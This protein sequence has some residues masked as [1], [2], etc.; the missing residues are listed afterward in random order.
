MH[1][2]S[3]IYNYLC[4][5]YLSRHSNK[6]TSMKKTILFASVIALAIV[7]TFFGC[8]DSDKDLYDASFK[9]PNPM[10]D[11]FAAPDG[12][13]WST[14]ANIQATIEV[15]DKFDGKYYYTVELYDANPIIS[16]SAQLLDR[17]VAKKGDPYSSKISLDKSISTLFIKEI[18][19]TGLYTVRAADISNGKVNCN[20]STTSPV[21]RSLAVTRGNTTIKEP[22]NDDTS[23]FPTQSDATE[24][25]VG[26]GSS[27]PEGKYNVTSSTTNIS[28][29]GKGN[30]TL[31]VTEDITLKSQLYLTPGSRLY[32][33]P[34]IKVTMPQAKNNGQSNCLISIGKGASLIVEGDIQLDSNYRL[35]N[36]GTFNAKSL[37]CTSNSFFYNGGTVNVEEKISGENTNCT[38]L[39][40]GIAKAGSFYIQGDSHLLNQGKME[41]VEKTE[42]NCTNGSW[43]NEGEWI[44]NDM[45]M[46]AWNAQAYN[47]CKL[48]IKDEF[49]MGASTLTNDAGSYVQCK[50]LYMNNA[51]ILLGGGAL[52]KVTEEAEYGYQTS[53]KGFR[54]TG[55]EKALVVITKAVAKEDKENIIHYTG[56]LQIVC[57]DHP[58]AEISPGKIRW[59]MKD[60]AEWAEIGKNT[61]TIPKT[62]CN[63][64]FNGGTPGTPT[65]PDFPIIVED[66][67][68]YSY[69]FEDQWPLYG[70]YDMNDIVLTVNKRNITKKKQ[71]VSK[72]E[73]S[74]ELS[75]V[76]ATKLIAAALMLDDVKAS[77]ITSPIVFDNGTPIGFDLNSN[78][79]EKG[80][81]FAVIPLFADAHVAM[82]NNRRDFINTVSGATSN[83]NQGKKINF[84]INFEKPLPTESF[85]INKFNIF[86]ITDQNGIKRREIHVAGYQPTQLADT[87]IF[88]GN[89]DN[90]SLSSKRYYLSN[91]NLAWGVMVPTN[92][93]WSLEYVNI[94]LAY[95]GFA[96]WVTSGG[97]E[98]AHWWNNFNESKVYQTNKN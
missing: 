4:D 57:S 95:E 31:Y 52:F 41:V 78:N 86:I 27:N 77:D 6:H 49:N 25:F 67:K 42:V 15:N 89:N 16:K 12:F 22:D 71:E 1:L 53:D 20:F 32:I 83:T 8:V 39:N 97:Q 88:G 93:K 65:D 34:G 72:L 33:L 63:E 40:T 66:N 56:A 79:I 92:F 84:T 46:S 19:P 21:A 30:I 94:K 23:L 2:Y 36:L 14:M 51:T 82:G 35:F 80:Q 24:I 68:E 74:I 85:N 59:T 50:E 64:G 3:K 48:L 47:R 5:R 70:D 38:M 18:S 37:M 98:N 28:L 96:S 81:E 10:G 45:S 13:D 55:N 90:S 29:G 75:A 91:E 61:I 76:G 62:D 17:D 73:F 44:T 43:E 58:N 54:G 9:M 26:E 7:S 60:G 87:S 11:G 69:I